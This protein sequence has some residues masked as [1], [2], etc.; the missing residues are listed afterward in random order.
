MWYNGLTHVGVQ[1]FD[2]VA[3]AAAELP[4]SLAWWAAVQDVVIGGARCCRAMAV[5]LSDGVVAPWWYAGGVQVLPAM[6][7]SDGDGH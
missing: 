4:L 7:V 1:M 3:S 5:A 2:R 6:G